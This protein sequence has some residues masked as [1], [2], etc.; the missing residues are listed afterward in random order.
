VNLD[1]LQSQR[2]VEDFGFNLKIADYFMRCA[3]PYLRNPVLDMG[4]GVGVISWHI[5]D[6]GFD[7]H[8][9]DGN[10]LKIEEAKKRVPVAKFMCAYID[11]FKCERRFGTVIMKNLLEHFT[12]PEAASCLLRVHDWLSEDGLL[13]VYVPIKTSLHKRVWHLMSGEVLG[14]LTQ[15]DREVGHRQI[16]THQSLMNQLSQAGFNVVYSRGLL[17]KPYMNSVMGSMSDSWCDALFKVAEDRSLVDI[18]SGVFCVVEE[19]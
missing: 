16:Y 4:C 14:E 12:E 11:E 5:A 13:I 3:K 10:P 18:C 6:L 17:V 2:T 19:S 15:L 1:L 7:V 8:G 9:V